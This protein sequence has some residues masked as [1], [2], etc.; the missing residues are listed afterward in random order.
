MRGWGLFI[1]AFAL[2]L[3]LPHLAHAGCQTDG[4]LFFPAPGGVIPTNARLI[5]E[6]LGKEAS[7][8]EKLGP[9]DKLVLKTS[10]DTVSLKIVALYKS[11]NK[12][13]AVELQPET[14]LRPN[15]VYTLGLERAL[16]GYTVLNE[17][18]PALAW[19]TGNNNDTT[20]PRYQ[21]K[22]A[23]SEGLYEKDKERLSRFLKIRAVLEENGP[24]Y[25]V[26]T[27]QRARGP[28]AKQTYPVFFKGDDALLGHDECSGGFSFE[29]GR[30]YKLTL[31]LTDSAGNA[32]EPVVLE[33]Q[34]PRPFR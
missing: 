14:V 22:P 5:L 20:V 12:R 10:D 26:A 3:S 15:R 7:R 24:A 32:T 25:F 2:A 31:T 11:D 9:Y 30:A 28:S 29:D 1:S 33:V 18:S 34:A 8:V 16:S 27:L 13:A 4:V 6:G 21:V 17:G 23:I 19:K